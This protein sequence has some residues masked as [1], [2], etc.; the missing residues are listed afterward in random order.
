MQ[1]RAGR[2][3]RMQEGWESRKDA[4]GGMESTCRKDAGGGIESRKDAGEGGESRKDA[5]EAGE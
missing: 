5:G 2:V 1:E 4:G 3:E